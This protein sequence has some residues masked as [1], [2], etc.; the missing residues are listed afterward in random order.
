MS[1]R[2]H[3]APVPTL[4]LRQLHV[5][6]AR[7]QLLRRSRRASLW[8]ISLQ[9][10]TRR[11]PVPMACPSCLHHT[12]VACPHLHPV[13]ASRMLPIGVRAELQGHHKRRINLRGS[14]AR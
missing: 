13:P 2:N 1:H 14:I 5:L 11:D 6:R 10:L 3:T 4:D 12:A 9:T 8:I 7:P